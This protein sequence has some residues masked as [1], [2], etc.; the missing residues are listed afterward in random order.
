ME[1][2]QI[3]ETVMA[4]VALL[5][6]AALSALVTKRLR[7]PYTVGLVILGV[8]LG[9]TAENFEAV[10]P[11]LGQFK[12]EPAMIMFL[13]IPILIFEGAVNRFRL[14]QSEAVRRPKS[15]CN[16]GRICDKCAIQLLVEHR[17]YAAPSDPRRPNSARP[18]DEQGRRTEPDY[19]TRQSRFFSSA[20]LSTFRSLSSSLL[21][22]MD[23]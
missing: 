10:G 21:S 12:L 23:T 3:V 17:S 16:N 2:E 1:H 4:V 20:S 14:T 5:F 6:L 13:F 11:V 22:E 9:F 15:A 19:L 7:F 8:A 18:R